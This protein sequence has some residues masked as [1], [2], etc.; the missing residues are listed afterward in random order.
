MESNGKTPSEAKLIQLTPDLTVGTVPLSSL[1]RRRENYRKMGD[2]ER[3]ALSASVGKFGFKT[4]V[5]VVEG[6]V[7][8]TYEVVD[9]HHRWEIAEERGMESI[10]AVVL[11]KNFTSGELDLAMLAFNVSADIIPDVYVDYLNDV[12]AVFGSDLVAEFTGV[13]RDFLESLSTDCAQTLA[14]LGLGDEGE[15][16]ASGV[17]NGPEGFSISLPADDEFRGRVGEA[18]LRSGL[19]NL[20]LLVTKLLQAYTDGRLVELPADSGAS[21]LLSKTV[22]MMGQDDVGQAVVLALRELIEVD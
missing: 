11:E 22:R 7:P 19:P 17:V 13:D 5:T 18:L 8:G 3:K 14:N 15:A 4:F 20:R 21:D 9:G 2:A 16:S 1:V 6:N 12:Q 10:P